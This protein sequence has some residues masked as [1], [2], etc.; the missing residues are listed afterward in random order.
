MKPEEAVREV[1]EER[2]RDGGAGEVVDECL[3]D[4]VAFLADALL[5]ELELSS[6][7]RA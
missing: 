2:P 7:W 6:S 1:V 4:P 3:V 5:A